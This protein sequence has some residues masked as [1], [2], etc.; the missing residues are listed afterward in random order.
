MNINQLTV[1]ELT[2][3]PFIV[4]FPMKNCDVPLQNVNVHQA[5]YDP[6]KLQA[7]SEILRTSH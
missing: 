1:C 4:S 6:T 3:G 2:N 7:S 5:G